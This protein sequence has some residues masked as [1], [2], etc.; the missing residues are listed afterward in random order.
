MPFCARLCAGDPE[1]HTPAPRKKSPCPEDTEGGHGGKVR[2]LL[3]AH[4]AGSRRGGGMAP[5]EKGLCGLLKCE[6]GASR[7]VG[8][9]L[10]EA[11]GEHNTGLQVWEPTTWAG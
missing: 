11:E 9:G 10:K 2:A 6:A 1:H 3:V 4:P 5:E 8:L 7:G